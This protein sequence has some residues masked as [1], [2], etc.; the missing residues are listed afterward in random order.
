[1]SYKLLT[2]EVCPTM[3]RK[4]SSLLGNDDFRGGPDDAQPPADYFRNAG[5]GTRGQQV[6][7]VQPAAGR[8]L[9][10]LHGDHCLE[11]EALPVRQGTKYILRSD[12]IFDA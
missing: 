5:A 4:R 1:M 2:L 8:A 12:V 9:L 6:A 10:H 7:S 11:H 3:R